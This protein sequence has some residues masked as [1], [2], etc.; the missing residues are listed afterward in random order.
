MRASELVAAQAPRIGIRDGTRLASAA[1]G[2]GGQ[3]QNRNRSP[4]RVGG[5]QETAGPAI[6]ASDERVDSRCGQVGTASWSGS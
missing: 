6:A 3:N 5:P 2:A 4:S 1:A